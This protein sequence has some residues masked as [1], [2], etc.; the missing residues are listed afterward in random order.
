MSRNIRSHQDYIVYYN[1]IHFL[2]QIYALKILLQKNRKIGNVQ[3]L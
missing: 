2:M 3:Q 1:K